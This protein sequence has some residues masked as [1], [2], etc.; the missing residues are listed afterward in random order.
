[1]PECPRRLSPCS[2][3]ARD[4]E[5]DGSS[6]GI[7]PGDEDLEP[8]EVVFLEKRKQRGKGE[9]PQAQDPLP[10]MLVAAAQ[11]EPLA[12]QMWL[13]LAYLRDGGALPEV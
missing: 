12:L 6:D 7:R 2:R 8:G 4:R 9:P 5:R 10:E 1:M 11:G 3:R 13:P